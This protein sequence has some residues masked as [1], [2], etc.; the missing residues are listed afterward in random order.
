MPPSSHQGPKSFPLVL[1]SPKS[2]LHQDP[3]SFPL[4]HGLQS[5]HLLNSM[6]HY[7]SSF[8]GL[9]GESWGMG[10]RLI[11]GRKFHSPPPLKVRTW[12]RGQTLGCL[13]TSE[14]T[15]HYH[16][17]AV[18]CMNAVCW[19]IWTDS[20]AFWSLS[21][22]PW[23]QGHWHLLRTLWW[24]REFKVA[25]CHYLC[26]WQQSQ[27]TDCLTFPACKCSSQSGALLPTSKDCGQGKCPSHTPP[28]L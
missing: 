15:Y 7:F 27:D 1:R 25:T 11:L 17:Q 9:A 13:D 5:S 16:W 18:G 19:H 4:D 14:A 20:F 28:V 10:T 23:Q 2:L 22:W 21:E 3:Q 12:G 24:V 6:A 8:I 26:L